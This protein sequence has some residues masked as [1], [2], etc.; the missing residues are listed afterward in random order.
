MA[1]LKLALLIVAFLL[2]LIAAFP[3]PSGR[4]NLLALG[5]AA[6]VATAILP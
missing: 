3:I 4:V 2:F 1:S 5:L 6:W